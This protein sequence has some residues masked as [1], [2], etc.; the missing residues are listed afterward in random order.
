MAN[1]SKNI[2]RERWLS[3]INE[4]TSYDLQRKSWLDTAQSNPHWSFIN[5]MSS[6]FDDLLDN[7][8]KS[9]LDKG[10]VTSGELVIIK[11]WHHALDTYNPPGNDDYDREA[12]LN[13]QKWLEVIRLGVIA[14]NKLSEMLNEKER[15]ILVEAIDYLK[16]I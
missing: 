3:S 6:Y 9:F 11:D 1:K 16:Y 12:I 7:N 2:W 14:K 13:D 15:Q 8:Y 10:W 5:F 4:L